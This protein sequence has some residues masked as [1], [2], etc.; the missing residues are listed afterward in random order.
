MT[1]LVANL[2]ILA[3]QKAQ[4]EL[5][6]AGREDGRHDFAEKLSGEMQGGVDNYIIL[7]LHPLTLLT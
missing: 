4:R 7:C 2:V 6:N 3:T 5:R 1:L